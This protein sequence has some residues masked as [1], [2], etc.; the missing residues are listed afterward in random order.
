[1]VFVMD[2]TQQLDSILCSLNQKVWLVSLVGIAILKPMDCYH[3]E[4][5]DD[6]LTLFVAAGT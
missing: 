3:V 4:T 2:R 6:K 5:L 1:M